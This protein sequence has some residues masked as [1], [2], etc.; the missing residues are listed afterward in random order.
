MT[1]KKEDPFAGQLSLPPEFLPTYTK[2]YEAPSVS[3]RRQQFGLFPMWW[4]ERLIGAGGRTWHLAIYILHRYWKNKYKPFKLPNMA[5]GE[6]T[7]MDRFAKSRSLAY[8]ERRGLVVVER[9]PGKSSIVTPILAETP[10][11]SSPSNPS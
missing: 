5:L 6:A 2:P 3:R 7:N 8:L 11:N 1:K 10:T 4:A 9:R